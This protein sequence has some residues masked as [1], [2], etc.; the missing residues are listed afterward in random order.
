VLAVAQVPPLQVTPSAASRRDGPGIQI[1]REAILGEVALDRGR[2]L[3]LDAVED[4]G[5]VQ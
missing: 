1:D 2:R 5:L 4:A 3:A